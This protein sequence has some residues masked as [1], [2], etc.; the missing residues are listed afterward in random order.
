MDLEHYTLI[1]GASSGIGKSLAWEFARNGHNIIITARRLELLN[2]LQEQLNAY[3]P[4]VK[5]IVMSCDLSQHK[6]RDR[7]SQAC[8]DYDIDILVN[9]AGLGHCNPFAKADYAKHLN[10]IDVNITALTHLIH[11]FIPKLCKTNGRILNVSSLAAF[12][13]GPNMA[14]YYASKAYVHSLSQA[15]SA[16]LREQGVSV[17]CLYPGPVTTEFS[18]VSGMSLPSYMRAGWIHPT[19]DQTAKRAYLALMAGDAM[20]IPGPGHKL[21]YWVM[22]ITPDWLQLK[23]LQYWQK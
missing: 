23:L 12:V 21:L 9:N 14:V 2:K 8:S 10:V 4:K 22:K 1:T 15:L 7:L 11:L 17:T 3:Y 20:I 19:A 13:P 5:V 18:K 16:E 6:E